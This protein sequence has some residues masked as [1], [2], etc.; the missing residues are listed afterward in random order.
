MSAMAAG[1]DGFGARFS[2]KRTH[3]ER[4]AAAAP[5]ASLAARAGRIAYAPR[6]AIPN[7]KTE[8]FMSIYWQWRCEAC[9]HQFALTTM[10]LPEP[11]HRCGGNWFR[12]VG[13]CE[14]KKAETNP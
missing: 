4:R 7:E 10:R 3:R 9:G 6:P 14:P 12:K 5:I 11:C 13:E 8:E 1:R 2:A